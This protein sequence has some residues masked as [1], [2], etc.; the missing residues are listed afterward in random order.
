MKIGDL[1]MWKRDGDIGI[2]I[3]IRTAGDCRVQFH[4]GVFLVNQSGFEVISCK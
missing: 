1:I 4:D 2:I 3:D